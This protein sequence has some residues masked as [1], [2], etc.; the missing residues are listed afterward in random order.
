MRLA[1][2]RGAGSRKAVLLGVRVAKAENTQ[3]ILHSVSDIDI[4]QSALQSGSAF[5][6]PHV[7]L[8]RPNGKPNLGVKIC[9]WPVLW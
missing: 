7:H 1:E 8:Q 6:H 2:L 3:C 5:R 4:A 9:K